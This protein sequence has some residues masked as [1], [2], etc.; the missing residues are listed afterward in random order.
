MNLD[1]IERA[2]R[3]RANG[4]AVSAPALAPRSNGLP[5][6]HELRQAQSAG[7]CYRHPSRDPFAVLLGVGLSDRTTPRSRAKFNS[8]LSRSV[9]FWLQEGVIYT[10]HTMF[11]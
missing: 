10:Y 1:A 7:S 8:T 4:G 11:V 3:E 6:E 5:W 2:A 9:Y